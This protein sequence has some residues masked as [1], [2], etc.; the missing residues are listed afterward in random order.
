MAAAAVLERQAWQPADESVG[1]VHTPLPPSTPL[2]EAAT[3]PVSC[4]KV[5]RASVVAAFTHA[6]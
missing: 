2:H 5:A 1:L 3:Q 4:R 6:C